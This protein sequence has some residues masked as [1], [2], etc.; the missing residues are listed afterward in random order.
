[1]EYADRHPFPDDDQIELPIVVVIDPGGGGHHPDL[2]ERRGLL[3][4]DVAEVPGAVVLQ[5]IAAGRET[6]VAR[7]DPP[8][9]ERLQLPR[10]L[11]GPRHDAAAAVRTPRARQRVP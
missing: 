9:D 11:P 7:H 3:E 8:P 10:A 4:R 1:M 2:R 5:E 6:V